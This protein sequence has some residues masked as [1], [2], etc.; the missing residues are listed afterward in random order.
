MS[1]SGVIDIV[2]N[3]PA[4]P[5]SFVTDSGVATPAGNVLNVLG[6]I[7]ITTSGAGN[8]ITISSTGSFA[9]T[10]TGN[11]GGPISPTGGNF[12]IVTANSTVKFAGAGST[13][14]EDFGLSNILIGSSGPSIGAAIQNVGVGS[15]VL[16]AVTS[17]IQN[18]ILGYA[19]GRFITT[20]TNNVC[21]GDNSFSDVTCLNPINNVSIGSSCL[22]TL[23]TGTN[24]TALGFSSLS[25][26]ITGNRNIAVGSGSASNYVNSESS[27][28]LLSSAGVASENNT[29]RI[30]A[31]G[32]SDGQQNRFFAAGITG[33]TVAASAPVAVDS[34]GQLSSLG[35]GTSTQVLTSNGAGVSPTWQTLVIPAAFTWNNITAS[36]A[37]AV[38]NGY[39]CVSPG[40][41]ISLS[42]PATSSVGQVIEVSL[43]GATSF[44]ITQAANQQISLG[45]VNTT[46]GVGGSLASTQ[47]GDT[48]KLVCRTANLLWVVTS[49]IGNPTI[50]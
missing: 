46:L 39:F 22:S 45:N 48:I 34:N 36:Q 2:Q 37:L 11:T 50:V 6:G 8:T 41:A 18:T 3:T 40:G 10:L 16:N 27:N 29:I 7:D 5:T 13:L 49:V 15:L 23:S 33:V 26:I 1:Q 17:G 21:I 31:Q 25:K 12:N 14:T 28:I 9:E 38:N 19:S 32:S 43:N 44:T 20:G 47:Q 30:G 4:I 24:N 42:L 35:F